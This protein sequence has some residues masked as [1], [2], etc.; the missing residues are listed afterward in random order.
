MGEAERIRERFA[1]AGQGHVFHHWDAL[2]P[3][4]RLRLIQDAGAVDLDRL[5]SW[6]RSFIDRPTGALAWKKEAIEP[7]PYLRHPQ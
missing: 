7:A 3:E 2:K 4:S 1:A 5:T 6:T